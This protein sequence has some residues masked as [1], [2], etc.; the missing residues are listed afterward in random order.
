MS[1]GTDAASG[2][3]PSPAAAAATTASAD[4]GKKKSK[5]GK[6][7]KS[8]GGVSPA[9]PIVAAVSEVVDEPEGGEELAGKKTRKGEK[10]RGW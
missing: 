1:T 7:K 10:V 4:A 9:P 5:S 2:K 8:S 3:S 6:G